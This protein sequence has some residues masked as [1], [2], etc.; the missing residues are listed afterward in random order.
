VSVRAANPYA[1]RIVIQSCRVPTATPAI[2]TTLAATV[3]AA[4]SLT[5][6]GKPNTVGLMRR[7][8]RRLQ[9]ADRFSQL[10]VI[11]P[12]RGGRPATGTSSHRLTP[13]SARLVGTSRSAPVG[14]HDPFR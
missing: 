6:F 1:R 9:N 3:L 12:C 11:G 7:A 13:T 10:R 4:T 14:P 5:G 2:V 8:H